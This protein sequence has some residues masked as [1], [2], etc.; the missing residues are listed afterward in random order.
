[1]G[2]DDAEDLK[3]ALAHMPR[4]RQLDI[5]DNPLSDGGIRSSISPSL[6]RNTQ[7]YTKNIHA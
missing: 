5:S 6:S 3:Y 4:L 1:M 7:L 2:E